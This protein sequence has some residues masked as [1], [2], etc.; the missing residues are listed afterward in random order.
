M[1]GPHDVDVDLTPEVMKDISPVLG[2]IRH[3]TQT[4]ANV[5]HLEQEYRKYAAATGAPFRLRHGSRKRF[6]SILL[7][8]ALIHL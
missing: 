6:A 3:V 8:L 5:G 1:G 2:N 7:V 4:V